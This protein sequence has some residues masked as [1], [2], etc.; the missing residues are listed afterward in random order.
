MRCLRASMRASMYLYTCSLSRLSMSRVPY[1][2]IVS[3]L[4]ETIARGRPPENRQKVSRHLP[5]VGCKMM[6]LCHC[7]ARIDPPSSPKTEADVGT[8]LRYPVPSPVPSSLQKRVKHE[9]ET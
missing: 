1:T 4:P 5:V 7:L 9:A 6:S 2:F 3:L 8:S